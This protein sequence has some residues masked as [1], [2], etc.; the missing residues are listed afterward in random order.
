MNPDLGSGR[1]IS[2]EAQFKH[3]MMEMETGRKGA[4]SPVLGGK[5]IFSPG[6]VST[7]EWIV[8]RI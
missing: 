2:Y 1:R 5:S 4:D 8:P 3:A 7:S 6:N